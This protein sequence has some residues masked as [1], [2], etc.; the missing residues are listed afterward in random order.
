MKQFNLIA[1]L[2]EALKKLSGSGV[3]LNK[4]IKNVE[5]HARKFIDD[6]GPDLGKAVLLFAD[7]RGVYIPK[8]FAETINREFVTGV[9]AEDY[10]ILM[11]GPEHT[12]Y[13]DAWADVCDNATITDPKLGEC[14][15]YQDGD[16]WLVPVPVDTEEVKP[17]KTKHVLGHDFKP[18]DKTDWD[19]FAGSDEGSLIC[20]C[21]DEKTVLIL[22]PNGVVSEIC[23][24]D[25]D[26]DTTQTDY[27]P[28]RIM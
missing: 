20:Y 17:S 22:S 14:K 15:L 18:F 3:H 4:E 8:E 13:W 11:A 12:D 16:L 9:S 23:H 1:R 24:T 19:C 27:Q 28:T 26:A 10:R 2:L 7:S 5:K 21:P 25:G 6:E